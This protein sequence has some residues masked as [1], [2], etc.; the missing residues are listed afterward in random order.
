MAQLLHVS[1]RIQ[2]TLSLG[3]VEGKSVTKTVSMSNISG[4]AT[5]DDLYSVAAAAGELLEYPVASIRK[6]DTMLLESGL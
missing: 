2:L 1:S 3:E 4:S 6:Y 5:A